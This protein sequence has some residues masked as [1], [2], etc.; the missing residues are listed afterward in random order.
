PLAM[1]R[2]GEPAV[3]GGSLSLELGQR[4]EPLSWLAVNARERVEA[5]DPRSG[6]RAPSSASVL[7]A[8]MRARWRNAALMVG[9][10]QLGWGSGSRGGLFLAADAPAFDQVSLA[11]DHPFLLPSF[12]R[13]V[14]PVSATFVLA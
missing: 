4:A 6:A 7:E 11:S 13:R 5:A 2:L 3:R 9:R 8:G 14:G 1:R 12:L 10:E